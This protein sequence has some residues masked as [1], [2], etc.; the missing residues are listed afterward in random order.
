MLLPVDPDASAARIRERLAAL[1]RVDVAVI[2]SDSFRRPWRIGTTDVAIGAAGLAVLRDL[3]GTPDGAATSC[4]RRRSRS[5]TSWRRGGAGDGQADSVPAAVI[6]GVDVRGESR[7]TS[8]FEERDLFRCLSARSIRSA[9][10]ASVR[11]S[12][13]SRACSR[14]ARLST[15][16]A[17]PRRSRFRPRAVAWIL[18]VRRSSGSLARRTRPSSSRPRTM[19]LIVGSRTCSAAASWVIVRAPPKTRTLRADSRA[20]ERPVSTSLARTFRS[21]WIAADAGDPRW[22]D[23]LQLATCLVRLTN[24]LDDGRGAMVIEAIKGGDGTACAR[25]SR[26]SPSAPRSVTLRP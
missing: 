23:D 20:G 8:S 12:S 13:R 16:R 26:R 4:A 19:P 5:R 10:A 24:K 2:V 18:D 14:S 17:R 1:A 7:A 11:S 25:C 21:R 15:R 22:H 3:R 9:A 6:R